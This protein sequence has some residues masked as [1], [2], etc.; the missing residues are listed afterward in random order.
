MALVLVLLLL[1]ILATTSITYVAL[2]GAGEDASI[3]QWRSLQA[4]YAAEAGVEMAM[5]ELAQSQD[6]DSDGNIGGVSDDGNTANNP[7]VGLGTVEVNYTDGASPLIT[8]TGRAGP[9]ERVVRITL[10]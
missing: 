2:V 1:L 10:Q 5:Q 9:A 4:L 3:H 7:A 6:L 8:A